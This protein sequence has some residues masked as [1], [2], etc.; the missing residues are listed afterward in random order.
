MTMGESSRKRRH[1]FP[2]LSVLAHGG[3]ARKL[4]LRRR[5]CQEMR[6]EYTHTSVKEVNNL[7]QAQV[8]ATE[9]SSA[10]KG[11]D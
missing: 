11:H 8:G 3:T 4:E 6:E 7:S 1:V 9:T 2:S 5:N 10:G